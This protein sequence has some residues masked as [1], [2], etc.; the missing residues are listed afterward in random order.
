VVPASFALFLV[1][2]MVDTRSK[3]FAVRSCTESHA[4][5]DETW[6]YAVFE[7]SLTLSH[8]WLAARPVYRKSISGRLEDWSSDL[9]FHQ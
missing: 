2:V 4:P 5:V 7:R 3:V 6:L 9:Q 8:A 1:R